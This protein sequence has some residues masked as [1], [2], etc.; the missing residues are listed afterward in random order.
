ME[1]VQQRHPLKSATKNTTKIHQSILKCVAIF[2][3]NST[4]NGILTHTL[5]IYIYISNQTKNKKMGVLNLFKLS[6]L[7]SLVSDMRL[8]SWSGH[9]Q[10]VTLSGFPTQ[11]NRIECPTYDVVQSGDGY[12]IRV[13]NS[14]MWATTSPIDDISFVDATLT[15][16]LQYVLLILLPISL[17]FHICKRFSYHFSY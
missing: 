9:K 1:H 16:F 13:Y 14:S 4:I 10:S 6:M 5:F 3:Y 12:E 7:L 11:C 15:G 17:I 8:G 2:H